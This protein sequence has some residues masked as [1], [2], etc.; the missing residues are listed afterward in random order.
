[1]ADGNHSEPPTVLVLRRSPTIALLEPIVSQK[2]NLLKAWDSPLPQDQFLTTHARSVQAL[3]SSV[4][5]LPITAQILHLLPS[6][7]FI[8]TTSAGIDHVD[9]A[10]CRR[11]GVAVA[12]AAKAFAEDAADMAVGLFIDVMRKMSASDR[13][14]GDGL[15][16]TRGNYPLGSKIGG[17]K[18]GIVGLGNI[19]LE[20]AKRLEAFGCSVLYNSRSE[21]LSLSYQFYSNVCELATAS[22][23]LIICCALT[24]QTHHMINREV[25]SALGREGVIINVGRGAIID[26]KEM[27]EYLVRGEI[28]GAGLD[29]F[30][31]EP[32]V[33][34]EL[35]ALDNVVLS[36]HQAVATHEAI[37]A[38]GEVVTGNLEAFFSNKP[39]LSPAVI[40]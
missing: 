18:V 11:R 35:Y 8:A 25:L 20:V 28:G 17:K 22:D 4:G 14:V 19:G 37:V 1:M 12:N 38:L 33:P 30:E 3:L 9:S 32:D 5:G 34:K 7:K 16:A 36:P 29:V 2:F 6:L 15:W 31:N 27:V 40:N 24:E 10:E 26:E 13:Y 39:L 21:K 23:A